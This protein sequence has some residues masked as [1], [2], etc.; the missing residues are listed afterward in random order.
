MGFGTELQDLT[1]HEQLLSL[2]QFEVKL[3]QTIKQCVAHRVK[4][5]RQYAQS[6]TEMVQLANRFESV[7]TYSTPLFKVCVF[8][9]IFCCFSYK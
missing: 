8:I 1:C 2:Q 3:L 5:E 6:L 7:N 4:C 9:L